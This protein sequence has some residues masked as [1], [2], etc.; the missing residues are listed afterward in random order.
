M[1]SARGRAGRQPQNSAQNR[2][3]PDIEP[4]S[5][6]AGPSAHKAAH[7]PGGTSAPTKSPTAILNPFAPDGGHGLGD[8]VTRLKQQQQ[9]TGSTTQLKQPQQQ[10]RAGSASPKPHRTND[11]A[12]KKPA[13]PRDDS[14]KRPKHVQAKEANNTSKKT[15]N[16]KESAPAKSK[17]DKK[18]N[19]PSKE[20]LAP[21]KSSKGKDT[22][23]VES[24]RAHTPKHKRH[25][26]S[27]SRSKGSK[28]NEVVFTPVDTNKSE[29]D[30]KMS[31][32][33]IRLSRE[34]SKK[35]TQVMEEIPESPAYKRRLSVLSQAKLAFEKVA[36]A[37]TETESVTVKEIS[38]TSSSSA[39]K[40]GK[41]RKVRSQ[42]APREISMER[43]KKSSE[44]DRRKQAKNDKETYLS[45]EGSAKSKSMQA[46]K[47]QHQKKTT[48]DGGH[49]GRLLGELS[50]ERITSSPPK[51]S[52][53]VEPKTSANPLKILQS[54]TRPSSL[55]TGHQQTP[56]RPRKKFSRGHI[57]QDPLDVDYEV[58]D[59][60]VTSIEPRNVLSE[61]DSRKSID[62]M[63]S[64]KSVEEPLLPKHH[65]DSLPKHN[66]MSKELTYMHFDSRAHSTPYT[67]T[68]PRT[69]QQQSVG[70]NYPVSNMYGPL[71]SDQARPKKMFTSSVSSDRL[72]NYSSNQLSTPD[73]VYSPLFK[74]PSS[75]S[76]TSS[77][78]RSEVC[79]D[80][81]DIADPHVSDLHLREVERDLKVQL[82][83]PNA[84]Y[85]RIVHYT[86]SSICWAVFTAVVIFLLSF[87]L[88]WPLLV[89]IL[90]VLPNVVLFKRLCGMLCCCGQTLWGR[91]CVCVC[92]T[93][94]TSSE[95]MWLGKGGAGCGNAI[96]QS[97]LV[98][99]K[100]LDTD[101][102]RN[103]IDSRL[104]S[105]ENRHGR[106]MYPR[107]TQRGQYTV[108][109]R[110]R[111]VVPGRPMFTVT[112]RQS[113]EAK[114]CVKVKP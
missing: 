34:D 46:Q 24:A 27:P 7:A 23:T 54:I 11:V 103:L 53:T 33:V 44:L 26:K 5:N 55:A 2:R 8:V 12:S 105:V 20:K 6:N 58:L 82:D 89:V 75:S 92:H 49:S 67:Q 102:I 16:A 91:C 106:K 50:I 57:D 1:D 18:S 112:L 9:K 43:S 25:A 4:A 93:H 37:V 69:K 114:D 40:G 14:A 100:G 77:D 70:S 3:N 19:S 64:N 61:M 81:P 109:C 32:P 13:P 48:E 99:Q 38:T 56:S 73:S 29:H 47:H 113:A 110:Q 97:L 76:F 36:M 31:V 74:V 62:Y 84:P 21:D 51:M 86:D 65:K 101:R 71:A 45:D 66:K 42:S 80:L 85:R 15:K 10:Q 41:D 30:I 98:L 108:Q 39:V 88:M 35:Q 52:V 59:D 104:L 94:L 87:L 68:F 90:V 28:D 107:F 63:D 96:A 60:R 72:R 78:A 22:L 95:L 111:N 79:L 83:F 17:N